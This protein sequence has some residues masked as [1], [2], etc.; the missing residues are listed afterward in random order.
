MKAI[1]FIALIAFASAS[2]LEKSDEE[3]FYEEWAQ[4]HI[5]YVNSIDAGWTAGHN[6]Y[7]EGR[8]LKTVKANLGG[9]PSDKSKYELTKIDIPE[10]FADN[11]NS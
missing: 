1:I 3:I 4:E 8:S 5:D 6:K 7:F 10:S 11:F 9:L 2:F